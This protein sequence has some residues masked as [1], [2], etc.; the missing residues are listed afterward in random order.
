MT[1]LHLLSPLGFTAGGAKAGIKR[2]GKPDVGLLVCDTLASAAAVFTSSKVIAAPVKIGREHIAGGKLRAVVVN[3]GNANACTGRKGE[4]DA[5]AMCELAA[6][7]LGCRSR[8]I[9]PSSTGII[10][11][12]LPMDKIEAGIA[13]A[14]KSVG[15]SRE[16]ALVFM[17]AILT[18]DLKRKDAATSVKIGKGTIL[19]A[20]VCKGSG[21][22]G[23]RMT[24]DAKPQAA[25]ATMLAYLTTDAAAPAPLLRKLLQQSTDVSFNCVT[26]DDHAST[27]DTACLLA[28]GLAGVK[29]DSAAAIKKFTDALN[30]VTQSLAYQ[31]AADGE[32]ATKVVKIV[33]TGA[34]SV[35]AARALARTIANSPLVKC[36]MNGNDPNWGR[37]VSAAGYAGVP[38]DPDRCTLKLQNVSVFKAGQPVKFD[39]IKVSQALRAPE[40]TAE[41]NCNLGKAEATVWTCDLSKEYVTINADYH[42]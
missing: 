38:F 12:L 36:A 2:S 28:S 20:G 39:S 8:E 22:I 7:H 21:M 40:V 13:A 35:S 3:S 4:K 34:T 6:D 26:V 41:L 14:A 30:E 33:V 32:G 15:N 24:T 25:H 10:G 17:D 37:I 23:P 1:S 27:N 5:R 42:T 31:I 11:H 9:L 16:H 29:L 18:T 19:L